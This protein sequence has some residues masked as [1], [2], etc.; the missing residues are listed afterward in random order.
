M[1][2]MLP[3]QRPQ[4]FVAGAVA[5]PVIV[6]ESSLPAFHALRKGG[7]VDAE[8]MA[9]ARYDPG[10]SHWGRPPVDSMI[11]AG[12]DEDEDEDDDDSDTGDY[13]MTGSHLVDRYIKTMQ[14]RQ[15]GDGAPV[16]HETPADF[17]ATL[18][19]ETFE[20][21]TSTLGSHYSM[22]RESRD[23]EREFR[24][25]G[26]TPKDLRLSVLTGG[27][28]TRGRYGSN[29]SMRR[30][31][32]GES[33][34][35]RRASSIDPIPESEA[36]PRGYGAAAAVNPGV[37]K[38]STISPL[39]SPPSWYS[40]EAALPA[41]LANQ[42]LGQYNS[43]ARG[44]RT[45][46][47]SYQNISSIPSRYNEQPDGASAQHQSRAR[48][49]VKRQESQ[50]QEVAL[51]IRGMNSHSRQAI[52]AQAMDHSETPSED[53]QDYQPARNESAQSSRAGA[54]SQ[55][56]H[57]SQSHSSRQQQQPQP[58]RSP[59]HQL[60]LHDVVG[61]LNSRDTM[62]VANAAGY[63]QHA[64]YN[65]DHVK[66]QLRDLGAIPALVGLILQRDEM[67]QHAAV[68]VLRNM[69]YGPHSVPNK[70]AVCEA[71]GV[72]VLVRLLRNARSEDVQ[73]LVTG[74]LWNLSSCEELKKH[75]LS[76]STT[77]LVRSVIVPASGWD[78]SG[79]EDNED[80]NDVLAQILWTSVLRNAT[81]ILRNLSS[82]GPDARDV[83]RSTEG[84]VDALLRM[85]RAAVGNNEVDNK[86][87]EN[88]MCVLRNLS[89]RM[90]TE[91]DDQHSTY[92]EEAMQTS[93][94]EKRIVKERADYE[95]FSKRLAKKE[96]KKS[97]SFRRR[98]SKKQ[99]GRP[100]SLD[101]DVIVD[102][103]LPWNDDCPPFPTRTKAISGIVQ[104]FQPEAVQPYVALAAEASNPETLEAAAGA[105]QN[106]T[107]CNWKW[108]VFVRNAVRKE[109]GLPILS[110]LLTIPSDAVV[111]TAATALRNLAVDP[112]NRELI[113]KFAMRDLVWRLPGE[114][115]NENMS[116][117]T[118]AAVLCCIQELVTKDLPNAKLLTE[119]NGIPII[120]ELA[121]ARDA[122]EKL[123]QIANRTC[124]ILSNSKENRIVLKQ[125]GWSY[126]YFVSSTRGR[127]EYSGD[128]ATLH[129]MSDSRANVSTGA[130]AAEGLN[131]RAATAAQTN[132]EATAV[133]PADLPQARNQANIAALSRQASRADPG[134]ARQP[135]SRANAPARQNSRYAAPARQAATPDGLTQPPPVQR[136]ASELA[137]APANIVHRQESTRPKEAVR[138]L[139]RPQGDTGMRQAGHNQPAVVDMH[140]QTLNNQADNVVRQLSEVDDNSWV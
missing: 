26:G 34:L 59:A 74:V 109:R 33:T 42:H 43:L 70:Y 37:G 61:F 77:E 28:Q 103:P 67:V 38:D 23:M 112:R 115:G 1:C 75:I 5:V 24:L 89:F 31:G 50:E 131:N 108:S 8:M 120:V 68:G 133:V 100:Q 99:T 127:A 78:P 117:A 93:N 102:E 51:A 72:E 60:S 73:E 94:W 45:D 98:S 58:G 66:T 69:S 71:G 125:E 2:T 41:S 52:A 40:D 49:P 104:L 114:P 129:S 64:S 88:S 20:D 140:L 44:N 85:L 107:A 138:T 105:I 119:A 111:R 132:A 80:N 47:G 9:T 136:Q 122:T 130:N 128:T 97:F 56:S 29:D 101:T 87:V 121:K 46:D 96:S 30:G 18:L 134:P 126:D 48:H 106:L 91:V 86:S 7:K 118:V 53:G 35:P 6:S 10:S 21:A 113:G 13:K 16:R 81:G 116:E 62:V 95:I 55:Q 124:L 110:E 15:S 12:D 3:E 17:D 123:S 22:R 139:S 27:S 135:A 57:Q 11:I 79:D 32:D 84:L 83:L 90:E 25:S 36:D 19:S 76:Q 14:A 39:R 4:R 54:H 63:L 65:N 92:A 137:S 82:A